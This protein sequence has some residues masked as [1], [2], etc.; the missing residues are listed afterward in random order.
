M[1]EKQANRG[2]Y[3]ETGDPRGIIH[4]EQGSPILPES[5]LLQAR[6]ASGDSW[7]ELQAELLSWADWKILSV[8]ADALHWVDELREEEQRTGV[9]QVIASGLLQGRVDLLDLEGLLY[10][11]LRN[12]LLKQAVHLTDG[13]AKA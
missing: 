7:E 6:V 10:M 13:I 2:E 3:V 11:N 8:F 9:I 12:S 5:I 4:A 1:A